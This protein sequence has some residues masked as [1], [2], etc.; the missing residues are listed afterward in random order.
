MSITER[1]LELAKY[2]SEY[3]FSTADILNKVFFN[4][5]LDG[6]NICRRRLRELKKFKYIKTYIDEET[7]RNVYMPF[8]S[9]VKPISAH[10]MALL[11]L[12]ASLQSLGCK[13]EEFKKERSWNDGRIRSDGFIIFTIK[14]RKYIF[15]IEIQIANHNHNLEKYDQLFKSNEVQNYLKKDFF[16]RVL[17]ISDREY[18]NI[19]LI[20]TKVVCLNMKLDGLAT[21][22]F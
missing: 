4:D 20:H 7:N 14:N 1:D 18:K 16:P 6:I 9:N 12:V 22:F 3:G 11:N 21:I 10:S 19:N 15:F 13:I 17:F 2:I 5:K 8:E